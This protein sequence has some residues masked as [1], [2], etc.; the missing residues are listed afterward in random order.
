MVTYS[1]TIQIES[2]VCPGV[3]FVVRKMTVARRERLEELQEGTLQS[4]K[5]LQTKI[6]PLAKEFRERAAA[7]KQE[8]AAPMEFP[9]SKLSEIVDLHARIKRIDRLQM[10]PILVKFG[11]ESIEGLEYRG[12]RETEAIPATLELLIDRGPDDLYDE[13]AAAVRHELGLEPPE[14]ENLSSPST[15]AGAVDGSGT[16]GNAMSAGKPGTTTDADAPSSTDP[17]SASARITPQAP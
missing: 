11:L 5:E 10:S 12:V 9:A 14:A 8:G 1:D 7:A 6:E 3:T 15:S 16:A 2:K 4:M 13:I 17:E